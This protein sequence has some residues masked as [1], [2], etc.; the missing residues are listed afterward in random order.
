MESNILC[1]NEFICPHYKK[2]RKSHLG[3]FYK[4]QLSHVGK[5]YDLTI[6]NK[7]L[8]IM[9]AGQ[10]YGHKPQHVTLKDRY[11]RIMATQDEWY[12]NNR[13]PHMKGTTSVLRL[14]F[15]KNLGVDYE[16]EF[17]NLK[18]GEQCHIFDAFALVN[19]LLCSAL[20]EDQG[21]AGKST[22]I[23]KKNC[24][25]HFRKTI[26]ILEPN[27]IIVQ[28]KGI[29]KWVKNSFDNIESISRAE[30]LYRVDFNNSKAVIASFTHPSARNIKYNWGLNHN[31]N[32]LIKTVKPTI[33]KI[34]RI[35]EYI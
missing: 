12:F 30:N 24:S 19:Y 23:M 16:S 20:S 27:V 17:L 6:N 35:M 21:M 13:N 18:E 4:G 29:W 3:I 28:G 5:S 31:T 10:E 15:G 25:E 34:Q 22:P 33:A 26:E 32:Y 9:V 8:R 7:P 14:L 11:E 2:C 1:D